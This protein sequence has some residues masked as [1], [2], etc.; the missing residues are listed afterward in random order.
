MTVAISTYGQ[1]CKHCGKRKCSRP[2]GLCAPCYETPGLKEQYPILTSTGCAAYD[3][4]CRH[5]RRNIANRPRGLCWKCYYTPGVREQYSPRAIGG[6][7]CRG[8]GLG[9]GAGLPPGMPTAA[10]PGTEQ[11]I[12]AM[13]GRAERQEILFHPE[14]GHALIG[15]VG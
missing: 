8:S 4:L 11:K 2:R 9:T 10:G 6:S 12:Q 5:C 14:D 15:N 1:P 7:A 3:P 13:T